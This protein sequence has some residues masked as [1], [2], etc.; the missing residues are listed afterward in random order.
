MLDHDIF[1]KQSVKTNKQQQQQKKPSKLTN[2]ILTQKHAI[3]QRYLYLYNIFLQ[4]KYSIVKN[5][6]FLW[7]F[8]F[9]GHNQ[10]NADEIQ[11]LSSESALIISLIHLCSEI[12]VS[13][14]GVVAVVMVI[15]RYN[16]CVS[17]KPHKIKHIIY[18][19]A[20]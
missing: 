16:V 15:R 6:L 10:L 4:I 12:A 13:V 1:L 7:L 9:L 8:F 20:P 19:P 11:Y 3:L 17:S 5:Q 14:E 18:N 2:T